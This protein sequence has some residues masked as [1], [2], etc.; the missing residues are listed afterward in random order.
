MNIYFINIAKENTAMM[1]RDTNLFCSVPHHAMDRF[2]EVCLLFLLSKGDGHGYGLAEQ[3][4]EFGFSQEELNISTLYRTLRKMEKDG[5]VISRWQDGQQ[6]PQK[7]V[8]GI[9]NQG[10]AELAHWIEIL[11][12]RK[13]RMSKLIESYKKKR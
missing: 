2:M 1:T 11:E 3:L 4:H 8:Y 7:R 10:K 6:G 13:A 9:T 12:E 5:W